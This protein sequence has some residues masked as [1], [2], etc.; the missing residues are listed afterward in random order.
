MTFEHIIII[1]HD[2]NPFTH[3]LYLNKY[4]N[5]V[6]SFNLNIINCIIFTHDS[7]F[8]YK[9]Q[10][11]LTLLNTQLM[12]LT[13]RLIHINILVHSIAELCIDEISKLPVK[14]LHIMLNTSG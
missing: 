9:L 8:N 1:I 7:T 13:P 11:F 5:I 14:I 2:T 4:N 10:W 12:H 3:I 6:S